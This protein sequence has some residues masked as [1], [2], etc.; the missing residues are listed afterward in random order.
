MKD[1]D[2]TSL[3]V[4]EVNKDN[5]FLAALNKGEVAPPSVPPVY[6]S[7]PKFVSSKQLRAFGVK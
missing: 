5:E 4:E 7:L 6:K 1:R 3:T 2:T